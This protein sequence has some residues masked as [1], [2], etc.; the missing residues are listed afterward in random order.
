VT[1][2]EDLNGYDTVWYDPSGIENIL[3]T[4]LMVKTMYSIF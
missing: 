3:Y 2:K 1:Q 4:R